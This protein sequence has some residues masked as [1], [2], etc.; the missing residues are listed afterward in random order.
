MPV[1]RSCSD[2]AGCSVVPNAGQDDAFYGAGTGQFQFY[3]KDATT[4]RQLEWGGP[5]MSYLLSDRPLRL[6]VPPLGDTVTEE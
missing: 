1:S 4:G 3:G 6:D 2:G 5:T